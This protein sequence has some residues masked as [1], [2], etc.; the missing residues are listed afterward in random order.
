MSSAACNDFVPGPPKPAP[1]TAMPPSSSAP[2][3]AAAMVGG[4]SQY[5]GVCF[6]LFAA[7]AA[8]A[9]AA[10]VKGLLS[11]C[12]LPSSTDARTRT[13]AMRTRNA[14]LQ[15]SP[16]LAC[17]ARAAAA[18]P[19]HPP[20][21]RRPRRQAGQPAG[22]ADAGDR[23]ASRGAL[24]P[25]FD[26]GGGGGYLSDLRAAGGWRHSPRDGALADGAGGAVARMASA[27]SQWQH[28]D[29]T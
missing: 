7:A 15:V 19:P 16:L 12:L 20:P 18:P 2:S 5:Q 3:P 10:A 25:R 6:N 4:V 9:A 21:P 29:A 28:A 26:G 27:P 22:L 23:R 11:Y 14:A 1:I 13:T 8:A 24:V 17:T